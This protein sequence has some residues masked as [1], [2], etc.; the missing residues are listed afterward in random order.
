MDTERFKKLLRTAIGGRSQAEFAKR[1]GI[2]NIQISRLLNQDIRPK[3]DTL[4][5]IAKNAVNGVTYKDLL[6]A[7]GY[8]SAE[9]DFYDEE[10]EAARGEKKD[11]VLLP[12][13]D[14][15]AA[16]ERDILQGF[17][18]LIEKS[19]TP[20]ENLY[21]FVNMFETLYAV[22]DMC[23]DIGNAVENTENVINGDHCSE[24]TI[25]WVCRQDGKDIGNIVKGV[26]SYYTLTDRRILV[27]GATFAAKDLIAYGVIRVHGK[28]SE[29]NL[30]WNKDI[31][32]HSNAEDMDRTADQEMEA[33]EFVMDLAQ[34]GETQY[35]SLV[36]GIGFE[37]PKDNKMIV[38]FLKN[39]KE[40]FVF[41]PF[42]EENF[43][44]VISGVK[45][46]EEAYED[47]EDEY[48]AEDGI[49]AVISTI[50][51][52]ETGIDFACWKEREGDFF[53][54]GIDPVPH[55]YIMAQE[56]EVF[57]NNVAYE[58]LEDLAF[59]YGSEL[60]VE[61][62]GHCYVRTTTSPEY[63]GY[64]RIEYNDGAAISVPIPKQEIRKRYPKN[65]EPVTKKAAER[66]SGLGTTVT[67]LAEKSAESEPYEMTLRGVASEIFSIRDELMK[68]AEGKTV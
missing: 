63:S 36:M 62:Y 5:K 45:S 21:K 29:D 40:S 50:I 32:T 47:Y 55:T 60:G 56:E 12:L 31:L 68:V 7:C 64:Y 51:R 6:D 11:R 27:S 24:I 14:R 39:H 10:E 20:Y 41:T 1:A 43:E 19:S 49:G 57:L 37:M 4:E 17:K 30:L 16:C 48:N 26:I 13:K 22:E 38:E 18:E 52:H 44:D 33:L 53:D 65:S 59:K 67:I 54:P 42:D 9:L 25:S 23:Y 8:T 2:T 15:I 35:P 66:L 58:T 34:N 3:L 28:L 61:E 46:A